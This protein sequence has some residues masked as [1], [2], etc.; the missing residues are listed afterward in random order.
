MFDHFD[1]IA[2]ENK[3][4]ECAQRTA[5]D[6]L[7]P[8]KCHA[9]FAS[10]AYDSCSLEDVSKMCESDDVKKFTMADARSLCRA[11]LNSMKGWWGEKMMKISD[12]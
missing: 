3:V 11:Q 12:S 1:P 10:I 6:M 9:Y 4:E 8:Q 5:R 7:D 2:I